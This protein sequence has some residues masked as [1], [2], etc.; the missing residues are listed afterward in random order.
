ME[1]DEDDVEWSF[2]HHLDKSIVTVRSGACSESEDV[3]VAVVVDDEVKVV[4][5]VLVDD[6]DDEEVDSLLVI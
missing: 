6:E 2:P 5:I 3:T 1:V 4:V